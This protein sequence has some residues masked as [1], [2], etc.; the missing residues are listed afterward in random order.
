[1]R[2][3][4]ATI[5]LCLFAVTS[6]YARAESL[7]DAKVYL[8]HGMTYERNGRLDAAI[9][10]YRE[11]IKIYP[12]YHGAHQA[13]GMALAKYGRQEEAVAELERA[14]DLDP[15]S[16]EILSDSE[17]DSDPFLTKPYDSAIIVCRQKISSDPAEMRTKMYLAQNYMLAERHLEK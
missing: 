17:I 13:L 6:A 4:V 15:S 7:A 2:K 1:M 12:K 14:R 5:M 9:G 16:W 8:F 3:I 10:A 11:A